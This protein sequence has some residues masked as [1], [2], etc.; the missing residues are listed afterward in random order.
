MTTG[1]NG[2][3]KRWWLGGG[4]VVA[5][6]ILLLGWFLVITPELS[7]AAAN[8]D[9]AEG[10]RTQNFVLESKNAR[11]KAQNDQ[12]AALRSGLRAALAQ[13]PYDS[14]LPEFT[15]Q[16]SAQATENAMLLTSVTVGEAT[17]VA[18]ATAE[19]SDASTAGTSASSTALMAI[20]ITLVATGVGSSQQAFLA[21]LQVTGPRRALVTAVQVVP[22]GGAES[23]GVDAESTLTVQLT[24]FS[25]PMDATAQAE[26]EKLLRGP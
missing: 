18:P 20:P 24:V 21:A 14:G 11:L 19:D 17:P 3:D 15:R 6:A 26:L 12:V 16:V 5:V 23:V 10:A 9:Q 4:A 8:R 22:I 13:L 1:I 25:A 7:A 2:R